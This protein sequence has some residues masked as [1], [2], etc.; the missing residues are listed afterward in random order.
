MLKRMTGEPVL[1]AW[2][3]RRSAAHE[4]GAYTCAPGIEGEISAVQEG[5]VGRDLLRQVSFLCAY[6]FRGVQKKV[7]F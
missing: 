6:V 3:K 2:L 1:F 4:R 5:G 7:I